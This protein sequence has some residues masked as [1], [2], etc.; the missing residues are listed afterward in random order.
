VGRK[1]SG[2]WLQVSFCN[3]SAVVG[4][5]VECCWSSGSCDVLLKLEQGDGMFGGDGL[6]KAPYPNGW[7]GELGLYAVGFGRR[8]LFGCSHDAVLVAQAIADSY[9]A[10]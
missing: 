10:K 4:R 5:P 9:D 2:L 3:L 1:L 6:P 8:G 7:K